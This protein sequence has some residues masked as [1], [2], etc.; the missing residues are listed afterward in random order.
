MKNRDK[1][2]MF[3]LLGMVVA[4]INSILSVAVAFRPDY[5]FTQARIKSCE[6]IDSVINEYQWENIAQN[7]TT[8]EKYEY[9]IKGVYQN[10][11]DQENVKGIIFYVVT[12]LVMYVSIFSLVLMCVGV[13]AYLTNRYNICLGTVK[14]VILSSTLSIAL[15]VVARINGM[16]LITKEYTGIAKLTITN[17]SIKIYDNAFFASIL[18]M[19][20]GCFIFFG[21][22]SNSI[23]K[24]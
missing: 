22:K 5:Y 10:I 13:F 17:F 1:F 21:L 12:Q 19:L 7:M 3:M 23:T 2:W 14:L 6:N 16:A 20:V 24:D 8:G 11:F 15:G 18:C 9:L 4:F